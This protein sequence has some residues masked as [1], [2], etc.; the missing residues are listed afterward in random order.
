VLDSPRRVPVEHILGRDPPPVPRSIDRDVLD[1]LAFAC[2]AGP[3]TPI[4]LSGRCYPG[5]PSTHRVRVTGQVVVACAECTRPFALL[6]VGALRSNGPLRRHPDC[7]PRYRPDEV[8]LSY[9]RG[10][11]LVRVACAGCGGPLG[12][13]PILHRPR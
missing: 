2:E 9:A 3:D 12:A 5:A 7:G 11:G 6:E 10:S 1:A 8:R 4:V 13:I